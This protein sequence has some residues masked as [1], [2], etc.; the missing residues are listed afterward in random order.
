MSKSNDNCCVYNCSS[1]RKKNPD[2]SFH[3][4]PR[5]GQKI[6]YI[7]NYGS[8]QESNRLKLWEV[9]LRMGKPVTGSMKVCSLHFSDEDF[10]N[11]GMLNT[12]L[13]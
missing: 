11:S 4:F 12:F 13:S 5:P 8:E 9:K 1:T 10:E 2:L 7:D 6:K 3:L